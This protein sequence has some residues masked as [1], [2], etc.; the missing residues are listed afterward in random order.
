[1]AINKAAGN[2]NSVKDYDEALASL[3]G[4]L[5]GLE[6]G[7]V[8]LFR[9]SFHDNAIMYGFGPGGPLFEG[10]YKNLDQYVEIYGKSPDCV[11]HLDVLDITPTTAVVKITMEDAA[12]GNDYT[13]YHS[14]IKIDGKWTVVAKLFHLYEK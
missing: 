7:D 4:Y 6:V 3:D 12:C 8:S 5:K 2:L 10:T 13:D 1:M 9:D 11:T 14:L